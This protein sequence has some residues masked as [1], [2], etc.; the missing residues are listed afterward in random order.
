MDRLSGLDASFLY[1][2]SRSQLMNVSGIIELDP[3]TVA[4]GYR[5]EDLRAELARRIQA[6]PQFRRRLHSSVVNLDHPVWV[7]DTEFDIEA[8]VH[9][10]AVPAPGGE[11]ELAELCAHISGLPLD[12][13]RPLWEMWVM[14]G[15]APQNGGGDGVGND[16]IG[17]L[18]RMHH[19]GVDGVTGAGLMAQLCSLTPEPPELDPALMRKSA[20]RAPV[21]ELAAEGALNVVRRPLSLVSLLPRTAAVPLRWVQRARR[22]EAMPAPFSAPR[23]VFNATI[24]PHR[25]I[26]F[27]QVPLADV[28][29]VKDH[30]GVKLNDVVLAA[31][32][33]ALRE[34]LGARDELPEQSLV[35]MIPVSVHAAEEMDVMVSGTN[36]VTGMFLRL[37]TEIG[38]P[39][40]RLEAIRERAATAKDHH[41]EIDSNILRSWAQ[42]APAAILSTAAKVY[43]DRNLASLHPAI[44]NLVVSNVPGPDFPLYFLGARI[45]SMYPLGPVFHGAG[46]NVTVFSSDGNLGIGVIADKKQVP[47]PWPIVQGFQEEIATLL[48]GIDQETLES[49]TD[50]GRVAK[51]PEDGE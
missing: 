5:F 40:A 28:K 11:R 35:S 8:H 25:S 37:A 50:D 33:G 24:G 31:V 30:F 38:D 45:E 14:E 23:T 10:V 47:D 32:S 20:G 17:V 2:E 21:L 46:L 39:A 13:G 34:Y 27:A 22:G 19:A 51:E 4:G 1:L 42:F 3:A 36:K 41:S 29:R 43:G 44:Y 7:E 26:A 15:L 16:R 49:R 18:V 9:R 12:R 48:T 6:M